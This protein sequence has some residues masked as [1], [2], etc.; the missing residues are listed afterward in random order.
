MDNDPLLHVAAAVAD[1]SAIDWYSAEASASTDAERG[2]LAQLQFIAGVARG[3]GGGQWGPLRIIERV[4]RGTFGDV[5]RAWDTRLDR[6]VALKILRP[7]TRDAKALASSIVEEG[8][9]L[10]RIRHPNVVTVYG[11]DWVDGQIGVWMQF[12]HGSTLEDEIRTQGRFD[13]PQAVAIGIELADALAAVHRAGLLHRDIKAR[14]VMRDRDGRLVLTDFGAGC[15]LTQAATESNGL[16][17][18]PVYAAPEVIAGDAASARSEVYSLGVLL[19]H[20]VTGA[21]PVSG[22]TLADIRAAHDRAD[23]TPLRVA[24]TDLDGRFTEIVDRAID[25]DPLTRFGTVEEFGAALSAFRGGGAFRLKKWA[26]PATVAGLLLVAAVLLWA[27]LSS[28]PP[29]LVVL[30]FTNLSTAPNTEYFADG[31]TDE[32]I[33]NLALIEGLRVRSRTSSFAFKNEPRDIAAVARR[34][35]VQLIVE[36]SVLREADRVRV[37]AQLVRVSDDTMLWS[38]RF[39]REL[40]DIFAIQDEMS[41]SIVNELRLTMGRGQRRY[42]TNV[43]AYDL[44]LK[45]RAQ[46]HAGDVSDAR[47]AAALFEQVIAKDPSFAPAHAGLAQAWATMSVNYAGVP[48]DEAFPIIRRSADKAIELEPLLAEAHAARGVA[49]ARER[50][51]AE[52]ETA[53]RRSLEINATLTPSYLSY[54]MAS[55]WPQ[56]KVEESVTQLRA[57][58]EADPLSVDVRRMLAYVQVSAGRYDEAVDNSHRALAGDP[59]NAHARQVLARALFHRGETA[60]A[61]RILEGLGAGSH[62]FLGYIYGRIGRRE[63]AEQLG[64]RHARFP[65]RLVLIH[66]GLGDR[67]RTFAALDRMAADED[68]RV[69]I[70]L[71]YPELTFLRGDP[72]LT[73]VRQSLGLE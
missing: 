16:A 36:G 54:V 67:D 32:V 29:V 3:R 45:A 39:D 7:G 35:G 23:R 62:N 61:L 43:A 46:P 33:R 15:D 8:R 31:L 5:Y 48:P 52:S 68:P 60:E 72:R 66:A 55:L 2:L 18:T 12:V 64:E 73:S 69:G 19:Y 26:W 65:A 70:Y 17:G 44:Y 28:Q 6:E 10:A 9:L 21:Y 22:H 25:P 4:G 42:S 34:L 1:G 57:A 53:F 51:W 59:K 14:N 71:T 24:R 50:K 30:P 56:G 41:R 58:L 49:L 13:A 27:R 38:A 47:A 11:A 37:N 20:L 63:E 40:T